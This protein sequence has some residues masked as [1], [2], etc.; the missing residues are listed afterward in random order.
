LDQ[1]IGLDD[2]LLPP[3]DDFGWEPSSPQ[4]RARHRQCDSGDARQAPE[5]R[6][7]PLY[8]RE[9]SY[10]ASPYQPRGRSW[11]LAACQG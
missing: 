3:M 4:F 11:R 5:G 1:G 7:K 9:A 8:S 6:I 10:S 2:I